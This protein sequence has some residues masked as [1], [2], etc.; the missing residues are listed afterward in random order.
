MRSRRH[1]ALEATT[2]RIRQDINDAKAG[3][4]EARA[5][6][7]LSA[8]RNA[9]LTLALHELHTA[10]FAVSRDPG[11]QSWVEFEKMKNRMRSGGYHAV[12]ALLGD[13]VPE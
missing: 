4:E 3:A 11:A 6:D 1:S 10:S 12:R 7:I 9:K 13:R 5:E 8:R 2:Q